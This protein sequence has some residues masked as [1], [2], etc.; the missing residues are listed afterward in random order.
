MYKTVNHKNKSTSLYISLKTKLY[1]TAFTR[2]L[3]L[4]FDLQHPV[5]C[6][7]L[8]LMGQTCGMIASDINQSTPDKQMSRPFTP[9]SV[10][11]GHG[12]KTTGILKKVQMLSLHRSLCGRRKTKHPFYS[13]QWMETAGLSSPINICSPALMSTSQNKYE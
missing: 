4:P 5:I 2:G 10:Y 7:V 12:P 1:S 13:M 8:C 9:P 6:L 11:K 3:H